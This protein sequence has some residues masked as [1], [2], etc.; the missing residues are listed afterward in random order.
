[1][2]GMYLSDFEVGE[3]CEITLDTNHSSQFENI[4]IKGLTYGTDY[5]ITHFP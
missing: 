5:V 2:V 3:E 4:D 1:M